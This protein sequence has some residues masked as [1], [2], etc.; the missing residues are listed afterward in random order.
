MLAF[1]Q[2]LWRTL[3]KLEA[4]L[5]ICNSAAILEHYDKSNAK[6]VANLQ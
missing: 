4:L 6:Q 3:A 1:E 2:M 5:W